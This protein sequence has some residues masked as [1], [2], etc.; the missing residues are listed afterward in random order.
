MQC[1][2]TIRFTQ[3]IINETNSDIVYGDLPAAGKLKYAGVKKTF[4][5]VL[6]SRGTHN[7]N[8]SALGMESA[9][10]EIQACLKSYKRI[11]YKQT[12]SLNPEVQY[13]SNTNGFSE[14]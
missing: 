10:T 3:L 4:G 9:L 2:Q 13:H 5:M 6:F 1:L 14:I 12:N 7:D 8:F 11:A